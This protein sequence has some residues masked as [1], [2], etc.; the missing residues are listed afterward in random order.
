MQKFLRTLTLLACLALPWVAQAQNT[1]T[2]A[3]G[4]ATNN[5]VPV[6]GLYVDDFVRSQTIYPASMIEEAAEAY[7]MTGGSISSMTFYLSSPAADSW[8]S[9]NFVVK[10]K[11]VSATTLSAFMSTDDAT[12]VYEG[13]LDGTQSTMTVTF[14]TPFTYNGGN[15][16]L[17]VYNDLE[18][19]Y[20]S[21]YF[22]GVTST[23]ASW[24]GNN[25]TSWTAITGSVQNF[26]PKT[27]FTFTGGTPITCPAVKHLT[28]VPTVGNVELDW[29][30]AGTTNDFEVTYRVAGTT[31]AG[32]TVNATGHPYILSGLTPGTEYEVS[33]RANCGNGDF[34]SAA[35]TTFSTGALGCV[36]GFGN[37]Q[38]G[39]GTSTTG[40]FPGYAL[41]NYA[42]T[43]QIFT[44]DE[45]GANG[46]I[47]GLSVM[48][49]SI[50]VEAA[51]RTM[52]VYLGHVSTAT[53]DEF[54]VPTDLAL[55]YS[56]TTNYVADEWY[57]FNFQTP[58]NYNG[59]DNLIVVFRDLSG[60]WKSGN[61]FYC[62]T[63]PAGSGAS[64]YIYQDGGAYELG[65]SGGTASN[66]RNN[67]IFV[68]SCDEYATCAAPVVTLDENSITTTSASISWIPGY[69]ETA[70]DMVYRVEG[71]DAWTVAATGVTAHTYTF[72]G[73]TPNTPY[74]FRVQLTCGENTFGKTV[75]GRTLCQMELPYTEDFE[76]V[77][78]NGA[79]PYCWTRILS[80]NTDPS[81]NYNAN[82]TEGEDAQYSMYM[83]AYNTENMFATTAVPAA[84]NNIYVRFW[85]K[86]G[87][88]TS[89]W[90]KAG[91]MTDPSDPETFIPMVEIAGG[92]PNTEWA[93]YEFCTKALDANATYYVAWMGHG[94]SSYSALAYVDDIYIDVIP[95]YTVSVNVLNQEG[96]G[97]AW[98]TYTISNT[99]PLWNDDV[100]LT[101][102]PGEFKRVAGWYA[103]DIASVDGLTPLASDV[104]EFTIE[105][106]YQ[107]TTITIYFGYGQF[108]VS[109]TTANPNQARM[110][111]VE[112]SGMYD[113]NTEATLTANANTGFQFIEWRNE[114]GSVFST[115][116]PLVIEH[117]LNAYSLI[118]HFGIASYEVS[119][120]TEHGYVDGLGTYTFGTA[121]TLTAI[122]DEHYHF[123][124]W[125]DDDMTNETRSY[126]VVE[127]KVFHPVFEPDVYMVTVADD[128]LATY[129]V[130]NAEGEIASE[131][132][133]TTTATVEAADID[134]HYTFTGWG[135]SH[136]EPLYT[137]QDNINGGIFYI[138]FDENGDMIAFTSYQNGVHAGILDYTIDDINEAY[139][140]GDMSMLNYE[141]N[142]EYLIET[143]ST[144]NPY[145][146]AVENDIE[147]TPVY[148]AE[149]M[150]LTIASNDVDMGTVSF[151]SDEYTGNSVTVDYNTEVM[152]S[153][154]PVVGGYSHFDGWYNGTELVSQDNPYVVTVNQT[155]TL[156]ANF[157][158]QEYGV[159]AYADPWEAGTI[160]ISDDTP[161]FSDIVTVTATAADHWVFDHWTYEGQDAW[162]ATTAEYSEM[163]FEP[164]SFVAHFVRDEHTVAAIVA[165][166]TH[167]TTTVSEITGANGFTHG[168][169]A[170]I[171]FE[172]GYGYEFAGWSNGTSIISTE[173]PFTFEVED[174]VEL[175]ATV[176]PLP[177]WVAVDVALETGE[178]DYRGEAFVGNFASSSYDYLTAINTELLAEPFYGYVFDYWANE[179]G[180]VVE[181]PFT[182]TQDTLLYAHFKKD[183]FTVTGTVASDYRMMGRV[184]G[185][186]EVEYLDE[187]ELT[188]NANDGYHF[189]KWVDADG[190]DY[191]TDESIVIVADKDYTF[192]AQFDYN[193]Y[194][195]TVTTNDASM[196]NVSINDEF[197]DSKELLYSQTVV[198]NA[199]A[200]PHHHFVAWQDNNDENPYTFI[201]T[202]DVQYDATFAI[203]QHT[204]S[205]EYA[206]EKVENIDGDGEYAY[207]DNVT[208]SITAAYGYTFKGWSLDGTNL[209]SSDAD[210]TFQL[211]D[212]GTL[213][214][215]GDE[216]VLKPVFETNQYTVT[217]ASADDTKGAA[218]ITGDATVDYQG[219]VTIVATPEY[220]Y[221][222]VKWTNN[223]DNE[224]ITT[225]EATVTVIEDITYTAHFT[226]KQY[227]MTALVNDETMGGVGIGLSDPNAQPVDGEMDAAD[228]TTTNGYVPV[229][230]FYADAY[231]KSHFVYPAADLATIAGA[232]INK[233]TFYASQASVDWGTT[234][235]VYLTEVADA[236]I[237][238]FA[239]VSGMT[240]VYDGAL[241]INGNEMV[242][243]FDDDYT[244]AGGNLLIAIEQIDKGS[245]S[246]S[247]WYGTTVNGSSVQGYSYSSLSAV[248]ASQ[249][250]FLPKVTFSYSMVPS[251][252]VNV[253]TASAT[254]TGSYNTGASFEAKANEGYHFVDWTNAADE[255][256][257]D[258]PLAVNIERDSTFTANFAKNPYTIA[259]LSNDE[260]Q[261]TVAITGNSDNDTIVDFNETIELVATPVDENHRLLYWKNQ[262]GDRIPSEGVATSNTLNVTVPAHNDVYTA[263]FGYQ[264]FMLTVNTEDI[265]KGGVYVNDPNA[266]PDPITVADGTNTNNY[267]PVYGTWADAYLRSQ[268]VYPASDL[269]NMAGATINSLTYYLSS[270][271]SVAWTGNFKVRLAEVADATIS[272]FEDM[273]AAAVAY[274]GTL[275]ATG[276]TMTITL[277]VP[278]A[279]QG[280]NLLIEVVEDV[281]GN[282]SGAYFY[283]VTT[284]G[285][286][287]G[288]YNSSNL[289]NVSATQR[290]FIPKT[291]FAYAFSG[292][293]PSLSTSNAVVDYGTDVEIIATPAEHYH[294]N[295]WMN[296]DAEESTNATEVITVDGDINL[297]ATFTG[298]DMDVT[299]TPN[300]AIRGTVTGTGVY[301]YNT[302][303]EISATAAHG[304]EFAK[305]NDGNTDNPRTITVSTSDENN[306][307]AIFDFMKYDVNVTVENGTVSVTNNMEDVDGNLFVGVTHIG[308]KYFYGQNIDLTFTANEHY[309]FAENG[310]TTLDMTISTL[311]EPEPVN[312]VAVIDQHNVTVAA[313]DD[314]MGAVS[315]DANGLYDY[316]TELSFTAEPAEHHHFVNWSNGEETETINVTVGD[317]DINLT[318]NFAINEYEV[319]AEANAEEGIA[320]HDA[321]AATV[322]P[323][324]SVTFTATPNPGYEFANWTNNGVEVSTENPYV[325]TIVENTTLTANFTFVG[326]GITVATNNEVMGSAYINNDETQTTYVAPYNEEVVLTATP[327]Y[328]YNF[329]NWTNNRNDDVATENPLTIN[330]AEAI[331]YTANFN[332]ADFQLVV[333]VADGQE[334]RGTVTG[335]DVYPYG[336]QVEIS[337]VAND[338]FTFLSWNDGVTTATRTVTVNGIDE[339]V[340]TFRTDATYTVTVNAE[341]GTV[342]GMGS[343]FIENDLVTLNAVPATGYR[344]ENYTDAAGN[345]LSEE[346]SY[347]FNVVSDT[348]ITANFVAKPYT[349]TLIA[350]ATMG[351][352]TGAGEYAFGS[353]VVI[354]ATSNDHYSFV[355]WS[356]DVTTNPR[357]I[358]VNGDIE[359]TALFSAEVI[360]VSVIAT[361]GGV[362][363]GA[364]NYTYGET[365]TL[366][367][368]ANNCYEF[369]GWSNDETNATLTFTATENVA[370]LAT[371]EAVTTGSLETVTACGSYTWN[372]NVY[373][374]SGEYTYEGTTLGGC[375]SIAVLN[376]TIN[377]PVNV[378]ATA[379]ACTEYTWNYDGRTYNATGVYTIDTVDV[380]GC[381]IT[382]TLDLTIQNVLTETITETACGSFSWNDSVYTESG[383]YTYT[384]NGSN[385]CDSIATLVLTI[386]T[387]VTGDDVT[388]TACDNYEWNGTNYTQSGVYTVV[389]P[390]VN[391][392]DS[393]VTLNLTINHAAAT[394]I[395][396]E[397]CDSYE[398]AANNVTYTASGSYVFDTLTATGCDSTVTLMLTIN[399]SVGTQIFETAVGSYEW[400]GEVYTED[401]VVTWIGT[402]VEGCDSTVI[403]TLTITPAEYTVTVSVNDPAMGNVSQSGE[404]TVTA[405]STFSVTATANA[406]YRFVN[407]SNGLTDATIEIVVES[408]TTLVA[409]F[410]AVIYVVN[411]TVNDETMGRVI[412]NFGEHHYGDVV[413][414]TAE[415]FDGYE[416]V[417][418]S[419]G[420]TN[421]HITFQVTEDVNL[422]AEFRAIT[423]IDD[424]EG[425]N[426]NIY[427][428][429]NTIVVKGA[430]N[431]TIYVYD[432]NGRCVRKQANATE[433]VEFT[434]SS[435]GVYLVKVGNAPAKR[436]VVVR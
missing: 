250:N 181:L 221:D 179:A 284:T 336:T 126:R 94:T 301:E 132:P 119:A 352:V 220:G 13:S 188:A 418:W 404:I 428:V 177:Y 238:S 403:L 423:G 422:V 306:Y 419:N 17:E 108:E 200:E 273:S 18:G 42:Y 167:G 180:E 68:G 249:R 219:T 45:I 113:Y 392:C 241:S 411:A 257:T 252:V 377:T 386:N 140:N 256:F 107:D 98:G 128:G 397:A 436:V 73:L 49:Q 372:N 342:T 274:D 292:V 255:H 245:Y 166:E 143:I 27:T 99:N 35:V 111:S 170:T 330:A 389:L 33:V 279:Y 138:T 310:Q 315:G 199:V 286:S 19:S 416:F 67:I 105:H 210:F 298:D 133:Y 429:D 175:T 161:Q 109:G 270:P 278:Y 351:T 265:N 84:G 203:D 407:W 155:M 70:W 326:F 413:D 269:A 233:M 190:N 247:S 366:N 431:L 26:I 236:S 313:N 173:N 62:H 59:T 198:L 218:S 2:V 303:V 375:D 396:V 393:T 80:Y 277:D 216:L 230:G 31:D 172:A 239:D 40:Y 38:V 14:T 168:T 435:T 162:L 160:A 344:F 174:D 112:G 228:G 425:S 96:T 432:V 229:Y 354:E 164:L 22:Y 415:A 232:T 263:F 60:T 427:S 385:G 12:T 383:V 196:G 334:N 10:L 353:E 424:V 159:T 414:L 246:T 139:G 51:A 54:V 178:A 205:F 207:G 50:N 390:A 262:A 20:K 115:E 91:V 194:T 398:W 25:G 171:G 202:E 3:D 408:D 251:P 47:Y 187:V 88:S 320:E 368:V 271:A 378:Q 90:L 78:N 110:G 307:V 240:K 430:E 364:G 32:T 37:V 235:N 34:G 325:M 280:G 395:N 127:D 52:E 321:P 358:V 89:A 365:V 343:N 69:Q 44:A 226:E 46:P 97:E 333:S 254:A 215:D 124:R 322:L 77:E 399:Q 213:E 6:Y 104:E 137:F 421:A 129:T 116:N 176:N 21:A 195:V 72:T 114:D 361:D 79:W 304:Y 151:V 370:L 359:L 289:N 125:A 287:V 29:T 275:N 9:A 225:A 86:M 58:F 204:V 264:E 327:E 406:G 147:L 71:A 400:N 193:P 295:A 48:P 260:L 231:L 281:T 95:Q 417:R 272:A 248:S 412:G 314:A 317:E 184:T 319:V 118:A 101:A 120:E 92:S 87:T 53:A 75:N 197:V 253:F 158:F 308:S 106:V 103:G 338:G 122:A 39:E 243:E 212:F 182:L 305:W 311:N 43:Q 374:A 16:L 183:L 74:E 185:S 214:N 312:I 85:A 55:V 165:D 7:G 382:A 266:V 420:E 234:F 369:A 335:A 141:A 350:D 57:T 131:F 339:Y 373:T 328:G 347:S 362:V 401:T 297:T 157:S 242:V 434:M 426:A 288:G 64:R 388:A 156:T 300:V 340:A 282:Y 296:G 355:Q 341:H 410:E 348:V 349:V 134:E 360:N 23:G 130:K 345:V 28:A 329:I 149:D 66:L 117:V 135:I 211:G 290:N 259:V 324:T 152:I 169:E 405:G 208:V 93:Q 136:T 332:F 209:L 65:C 387:P 82:H 186:D 63:A 268:V 41:Y 433:T 285:A 144:E 357:T 258:N 299:V 142:H 154:Q 5:Y 316:G 15:L 30:F 123:V 102:T 294:F 318:A 346:A 283:G 356:D 267:I 206:E 371:F 367:A 192:Y 276:S 223:V 381:D 153:A 189:T 244:Y 8:G 379:Q 217:V 191:S 201:L 36:A 24:R 1:L 56:G 391:G 363:T 100:E 11:E 309:H 293:T 224:V 376:L 83:Q 331:T 291:T 380:N 337:A 323:N 222:F 227:T 237:S 4:T 261:G 145:T 163:V 146:F 409:N 384:T 302:E 81:V 150:T 148:E 402:T 61:N 121:V 394:T 76:S